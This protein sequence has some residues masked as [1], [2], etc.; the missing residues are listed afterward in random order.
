[1]TIHLLKTDRGVFDDVVSGKKS[2]EVRKDDRDP[3]YKTGDVVVLRE[4][5]PGLPA[6]GGFT[7]SRAVRRIGYLL[8][9]EA[10]LPEGYVVFELRNPSKDEEE[11]ARLALAEDVVVSK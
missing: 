4:H 3:R 2:F 10:Y 8:R 7:R 5:D 1:M 11:L 6:P 9:D